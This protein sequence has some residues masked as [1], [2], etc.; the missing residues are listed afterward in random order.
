MPLLEY[1]C[2]DCSHRFERM[3]P[4]GGKSPV[5]CPRCGGTTVRRLSCCAKIIK[6]TVKGSVFTQHPKPETS[7]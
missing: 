1:H 2:K 3:V 4:V 6:A 7:G 5:A